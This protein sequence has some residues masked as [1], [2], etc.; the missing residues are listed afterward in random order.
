MTYN[1]LNCFEESSDILPHDGTIL[2][3]EQAL[4]NIYCFA[5][6]KQPREAVVAVDA[7]A[8]VNVA[9]YLNVV[10]A[11]NAAIYVDVVYAVAVGTEVAVFEGPIINVFAGPM[12]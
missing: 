10:A 6:R 2:F 3:N 11:Q 5:R 8:A 12:D 7:V 9:G 4:N 1:F